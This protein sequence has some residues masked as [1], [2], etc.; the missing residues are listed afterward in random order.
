MTNEEILEMLATGAERPSLR[1]LNNDVVDDTSMTDGVTEC[2]GYD[3][4]EDSRKA[5]YC[6]ICGRKI[7]KKN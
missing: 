5:R 1:E 3:F 2:C 4:G 6:P 7:T